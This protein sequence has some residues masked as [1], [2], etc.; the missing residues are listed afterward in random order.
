MRYVSVKMYTCQV[1][2]F[3]L[4]SSVYFGGAVWA[5]ENEYL[6]MDISQLM[7]V[8]ITSVSKKPEPLSSA[9]A[10]VYVITQEDIRR[11]GVTN[12]AEALRL[13]PGLQVARISAN[14]WAI[15]SRG[16]NGFFSNKLLVMIDGRTIYNPAFAGTYWDMQTT[17]LED[18]NRIE[19]IRGPGAT[20]WGAN[21]VNG[22]INIIT[23]NS[24]DTLG[25]KAIAGV[26]TE[27]EVIAGFRYGA[28]INSSIKG[29]LYLTYNQRDSFIAW[30]DASDA[31][32]SWDTVGGGF[33][34]D[35]DLGKASDW[36]VQGDL[37]D[38]NENQIVEPFFVSSPPYIT[39]IRDEVEARGWNLLGKWNKDLASNGSVKLQAYYDYAKRD[40]AYGAQTHK[41]LDLDLQYQNRLGEINELT[42]GIGYR[43]IETTLDS[44]FQISMDPSARTDELY[45]GFIQDVFTVVPEKLWLTVGS[46][47]EH[48]D[49]TG[50]EIQ[51]TGR[52]MWQPTHTQSVW[53][54]VSRAVRTPSQFDQN[55]RITLGVEPTLPP[56]PAVVVVN[57]NSEFESEEVFAYEAG[58][59]WFPNSS[60]SVDL[61]LFYNEYDNVLSVVPEDDPSIW[62]DSTFAN[63]IEGD[64]YG[65]ELAVEWQP[66]DW[67]KFHFT[68]S[69]LQLDFHTTGDGSGQSG[70]DINEGNSPNHQ[71]ALRGNFDLLQN[72][73]A[74]I[75]LRYVSELEVASAMAAD[76]NLVVDEYYECDLNVTWKPRDDLE[77][78]LAGQN[79]LNSSHMEFVSEFYMMPVEVQRGVYLKVTYNF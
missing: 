58:Y 7:Q 26:G 10:A 9:A 44:S 51:P 29:R 22:V 6:D 11:S 3:L 59:R 43:N 23:E 72:F 76:L 4:M 42:L 14:K 35:G 25:G 78:I 34:L 70:L 57:G 45:S 39:A 55:G 19:V 37:Y 21:A 33:R 74:N 28:E 5:A 38:I 8:T 68:Y 47:W 32:D 18:V 77:V 41:T 52:A 13:A 62:W 79:L 73:Q 16:F 12:I 61:A 24:A 17:L 66:D 30:S 15:S 67:L 50:N 40:E 46:K 71:L 75:W 49:F 54:S 56:Y 64:S 60:F 69:Y 63:T 20:M 31:Y 36:T 2:A 53:T 48:N 65:A 27:E 1:S